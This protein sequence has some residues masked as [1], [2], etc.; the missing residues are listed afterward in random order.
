MW[1]GLESSLPVHAG[2]EPLLKMR[3]VEFRDRIVIA[4]DVATFDE[5]CHLMEALGDSARAFKVGSQLFTG[6]GPDIAREVK[7]RGKTLFLD[8]KFHDIPNTVARAS[9]AAAE[10]RVDMFNVH[11]SG[12]LDMMRAA[13][14]AA[15]SKAS[16]LGIEK[17]AALGVT[18]LTSIDDPAFRRIFGRSNSLQEQVVYMAKL[19]QNAGLDG[20]VASPQE[21]QGVRAACGDDFVVVTPGVRPEWSTHDDQ[22][23]TMTPAQAL[24]AGADYVVIGR[25]IY[26]SPDPA[27]AMARLLEQLEKGLQELQQ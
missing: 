23:R 6:V 27:D 10:L 26:Q 5:A 12:G 22:K 15:K 20:V 1:V 9:E 7:G 18:I 17:P 4:L 21:I 24:T 13:A 16:D 19:A 2:E 11:I 8:L 25:P 14:E 3:S